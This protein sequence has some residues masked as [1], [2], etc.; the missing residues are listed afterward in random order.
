VIK[1]TADKS[2]VVHTQL[3]WLSIAAQEP[4]RGAK[5]MLIN[6]TL[7][8]AT[9]GVWYPGNDWTHWFPLPTFFTYGDDAD[10]IADEA[11]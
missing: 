3:K 2:A 10:N 9:I 6:R 8:C 4:P 7:G 1:L 5:V 11:L